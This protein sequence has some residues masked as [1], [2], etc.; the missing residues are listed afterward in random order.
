MQHIEKC[1]Y[2][3][4]V[5]VFE[6]DYICRPQI[7][8][9]K[10]SWISFHNANTVSMLI[11]W[12]MKFHALL[13]TRWKKLFYFMYIRIP[14][15]LWSSEIWQNSAYKRSR[16]YSV[17]YAGYYK[18]KKV[19]LEMKYNCKAKINFLCLVRALWKCTESQIEIMQ[20]R[21]VLADFEL[22]YFLPK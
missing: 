4:V 11:A 20:I 10:V 15:M 13:A 12:Q 18:R 9:L 8:Q 16:K 3:C 5:H 1:T 17:L 14:P 21:C 22:S 19:H 7:P 2:V 6:V